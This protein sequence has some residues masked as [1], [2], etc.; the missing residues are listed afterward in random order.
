M[1]YQATHLREE[2]TIH[3]II[4]IHY[5]EYMSDFTFPGESHGFWEFLCVDKGEVGV[6]AGED[7]LVL[8]RGDIIFHKP[9]EFHAVTANGVTAPNLV[10]VAFACENPCMEFFENKV[11][12]IGES[13]RSLIA[14]IITEAKS[15]F[16]TVLDNPYLEQL[17]RRTD[18]SFGAEQLIKLH[19]E[20]LLIQ[21][22]R[23]FSDYH[24]LQAQMN[25]ADDSHIVYQ[26][27]IAYFEQNIRRPLTLEQI[28][29]DNLISSS[30][31]KKLFRL[32]HKSGV[33]EYFTAMKISQAKQLIRNHQ[34]N[35][36]QIADYLGYTSV[37]Y[38]SRQFKKET[39]MTPSE[40]LASI[41]QRTEGGWNA[42]PGPWNAR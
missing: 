4:S 21:L 15:C 1:N 42:M 26:E 20:Q 14:Q 25:S 18:T 38:F 17:E 40:Y 3:D 2:L 32:R 37:H 8:K 35:F 30:L 11:L 10:V 23:S 22:H 9:D 33:I 28:C 41:K 7:F 6:T 19:L 5:F 31:L 29:R 12:T 34:M 27:V 24:Q 13:E 16:S 39:G 36:T